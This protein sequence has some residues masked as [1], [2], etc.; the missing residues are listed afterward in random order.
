MTSPLYDRGYED[1]LA[2]REPHYA[3]RFTWGYRMGYKIGALARE[4]RV[5]MLRRMIANAERSAA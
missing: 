2:G 4:N 3:L 5:E 1:G